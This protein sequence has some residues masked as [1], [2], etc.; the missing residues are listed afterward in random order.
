MDRM[1][2][3]NVSVTYKEESY[4]VLHIVA[5]DDESDDG[6]THPDYLHVTVIDENG[7]IATISDSSYRFV[8]SRR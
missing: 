4:T 8:F 2:V 3:S 1:S 7:H 5:F 6:I